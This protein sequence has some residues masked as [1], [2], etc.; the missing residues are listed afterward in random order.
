MKTTQLI[1]SA[2]QCL[3]RHAGRSFL[4]MLGIIIGIASIIA[5]LAIGKGAEQQIQAQIAA[6]GDNYIGISPLTTTKKTKLRIMQQKNRSKLK[7]IDA[8]LLKRHVPLID[9]ISP[10]IGE[11]G[12]ITFQ[13]ASA[14]VVI[15]GGNEDLLTIINRTPAQGTLF[16]KDHY[17]RQS[18]SIVLGHAVAQDLGCTVGQH[19]RLNSM[20]FHVIGILKPLNSYVG[21][22]NPNYN[23]FIPLTTLKKYIQ[24]RANSGIHSLILH[25]QNAENIPLIIA[26]VTHALRLRHRLQPQEPDDFL[27]TTQQALAQTAA[28]TSSTFNLFLFL[29]GLISLIVGGIGI[30]N[31]MLV[32]VSERQ[33]EIGIR[34][35][36]GATEGNIQQQFL[37]EA[38]VLCCIGGMIGILVGLAG[39]L[40]TKQ[41]LGWPILVTLTSILYSTG[42]TLTIGIF[43]GAY[44]A[45]QAS[46]L[47]PVDALCER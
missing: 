47:N 3:M 1:K 23:V 22:E 2:H 37:I 34:L 24:K 25:A 6:M 14:E 32:A 44:P 13:E 41:I 28:Q 9:A 42:I 29:V 10:Y 35:A 21:T 8:Q 36:L 38:I 43:F 11:K 12:A 17:V 33:R 45:Y 16:Q 39:A 18:R 20:P 40:I 7:I 26:Q 5:I 46:Q 31:I 19:V 27:I 30:M 15:K 4:T